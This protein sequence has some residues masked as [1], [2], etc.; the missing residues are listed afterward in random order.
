MHIMPYDHTDIMGRYIIIRTYDELIQEFNRNL[1]K[2]GDH[3]TTVMF[4]H[5]LLSPELFLD[6]KRAQ[7]VC[8]TLHREIFPV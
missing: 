5:Q 1:I 2:G 7:L 4:Y 8:Q 6:E 3:K